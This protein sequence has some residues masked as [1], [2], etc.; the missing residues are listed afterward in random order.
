MCA[1]CITA[2]DTLYTVLTNRLFLLKLEFLFWKITSWTKSLF[3]LATETILSDTEYICLMEFNLPGCFQ[4]AN[5]NSISLKRWL[6][7]W[8]TMKRPD[9]CNLCGNKLVS[10]EVMFKLIFISR[11]A[12]SLVTD[13]CWWSR[14]E[15]RMICNLKLILTYL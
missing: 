9:F 12:Y 4:A 11:L 7:Q 6:K 8:I 13:D 3:Y 5:D 14:I 2:V 10:L 1:Q 15:V